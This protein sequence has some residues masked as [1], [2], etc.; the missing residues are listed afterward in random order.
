MN[1]VA[2]GWATEFTR[3]LREDEARFRDITGR[4]TLGRWATPQEIADSVAFLVSPAAAYLQGHIL[5]TD[6]GYLVR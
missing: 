3:A 5:V 2:P 6:G 4:I 1:A